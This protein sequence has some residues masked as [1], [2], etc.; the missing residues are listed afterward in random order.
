MRISDAQ[1][2]LGTHLWEEEVVSFPVR[3]YC[4][5]MKYFCSLHSSLEKHQKDVQQKLRI[6]WDSDDALGA[7]LKDTVCHLQPYRDGQ[8]RCTM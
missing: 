6:N 4:K 5:E 7:G 3:I 8:K 1:P 2:P